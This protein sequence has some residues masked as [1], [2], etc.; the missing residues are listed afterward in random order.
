MHLI[1]TARK[2]ER[3]KD[4]LGTNVAAPT[5]ACSTFSNA[6]SRYAMRHFSTA[7]KMLDLVFT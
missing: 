7:W 4:G 3:K 5:A 1:E 2:L 6:I